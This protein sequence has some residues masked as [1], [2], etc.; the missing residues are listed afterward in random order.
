MEWSVHEIDNT[1]FQWYEL[2]SDSR[3]SN[4]WHCYR[5]VGTKVHNALLPEEKMIV[6]R[7]IFSRPSLRSL[8]KTAK[9]IKRQWLNNVTEEQR[10][11]IES[12]K[13]SLDR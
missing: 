13:Y 11:S 1:P 5:R 8:T 2:D 9:I 12:A 4:L 10:H 6:A 3:K 7:R